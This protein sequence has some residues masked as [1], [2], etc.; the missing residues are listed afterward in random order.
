MKL[1]KKLIIVRKRNSPSAVLWA[2][3]IIRRYITRLKQLK[4]KL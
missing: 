2:N 4:K 3:K 1:V